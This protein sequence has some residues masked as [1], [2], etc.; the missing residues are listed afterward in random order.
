MDTETKVNLAPPRIERM[1]A[2]KFAGIIQR[3]D[4]NQPNSIP[5]QWQRLQPYLGNI[6]G[7]VP[8]NAYG[9][10]T[11]SD[12]QFCTYLCGIEITPSAELPSE[13]VAIGVPSQRWARFAHTAHISAIRSTIRAIYDDWMP[14]S[15]ERQAEGT[16]FIEYYGPDFD[17]IAGVGTVEI[18]IGLVD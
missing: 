2:R 16:S 7:A 4:M 1:P 3:H 10:T 18:W 12:G 8:G 13:F 5:A 11:E 6:R 14:G 15:G 9:I 17:P